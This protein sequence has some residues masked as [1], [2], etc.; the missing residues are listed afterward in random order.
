MT[1][2]I[3]LIFY[4]KIPK[5]IPVH[6]D[7]NGSIN[8]WALKSPGLILYGPSIQLFITLIMIFVYIIIRKAR[9]QIDASKPE[10]SKERIRIFRKSWNAFTVFGGLL[11]LLVFVWVQVTLLGFVK[12][13]ILIIS[14]PLFLTFLFLIYII[15]LSV[16]IGQ[17][18]SRL[19]INKSDGKDLTSINR[20]DDRFWKFGIF[21]YNPDD[22]ALFLEKRFGIG[23]TFNFARPMIWF[24]LIGFI[25][26]ISVSIIVSYIPLRVKS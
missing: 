26:L 2:L 13:L 25:L 22:P 18:G 3:G 4:D 21:Y 10:E 24:I 7:I 6:Y 14:L 12:N 23:W 11:M 19:N 20:D 17:G 9:Q 8:G 15:I 16:K 5:R 1:V